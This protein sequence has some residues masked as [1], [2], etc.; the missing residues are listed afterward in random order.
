MLGFELGKELSGSPASSLLCVFNALPDPLYGILSRRD[1]E[2][3]LICG[4]T[5]YDQFRFPLVRENQGAL[6]FLE[7]L[8]EGC[9]PAAEKTQR[10]KVSRQ[11]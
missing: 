3:A 2:K 9:R 4:G 1:I 8:G 11:V 6:A 10:L 5:L 7:Q